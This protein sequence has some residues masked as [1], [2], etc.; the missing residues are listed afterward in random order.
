MKEKYYLNAMLA[1]K[2]GEA[3]AKNDNNRA[4][5]ICWHTP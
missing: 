3:T 5:S 1:S 2:A 4:W